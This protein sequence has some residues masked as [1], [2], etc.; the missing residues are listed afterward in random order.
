[1]K[2]IQ[3]FNSKNKIIASICV[4]ALALG[5]SGILRG[6]RATTYNS[7]ER[8]SALKEFNAQVVNQPV[9]MDENIITS[10]NPASAVDVSLLLL[11][12]LTNKE[13]SG[14]IRNIMGF[15]ENDK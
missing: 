15:S 7:Q 6:K 1:M 5:K 11:E 8:R 10:C 3:D 14:Y 12:K 9:V 13:N 4:A 2:I